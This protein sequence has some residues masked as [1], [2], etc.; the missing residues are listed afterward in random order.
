[1]GNASIWHVPYLSMS[2]VSYRERNIAV[3]FSFRHDDL[4]KMFILATC[5]GGLLWFQNSDG[6]YTKISQDP[7]HQMTCEHDEHIEVR[8]RQVG[9][10]EDAMNTRYK[11]VD[12]ER[13]IT[14]RDGG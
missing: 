11:T 10:S 12:R 5:L 4:E 14:G 7:G 2:S 13:T 9:E 8:Y 1:M 3:A 6:T